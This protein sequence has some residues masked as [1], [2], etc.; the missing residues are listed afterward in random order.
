MHQTLGQL[1]GACCWFGWNMYFTGDAK[2]WWRIR[3]K[4]DA[5]SGKPQI[6]T[7]ETLKNELK[8]QFIPTNIAWV[9]S[10]SLKRFRHTRSVRDYV[11]EFSSLMLDIKNMLEEDKFFNFMSG[12]Q[13]WVRQNFRGKGFIA[14]WIT[15]WVVPSPLC[16]TKVEGGKKAKAKGKA[17]K[18]SRWKKQNKKS[19]IGVK[20]MEKTTK[21]VQQDASKERNSRPLCLQMTRENLTQRPLLESIHCNSWMSFMVKV[22]M[23][24]GATHNFMATREATGLGLKLKE[25]TIRFKAVNSKVAKNV[26]M[27]VSDW[28][29]TCSLLC[30]P[31]DDFNFILALRA[32]D[33]SKSQPKMLS[34]IQ[35]K[36]G[37]KRGHDTY[38][39]AL[40]EIKEEYPLQDISYK[41]IGAT[42]TVE[43][44]IGC[45][46][47][48]ALKGSI[49]CTS[50]TNIPTTFC[51]LMND[52]LFDYLDAFVRLR[53]HR[54]YVKPDKCEA[55]DGV[56]VQE[57]HP[58]T[59]ENRKLNSAEQK[60]S[61]REKEMTIVIHCFRKEVIVYIS[62]LSKVISDFNERIKQVV[63][64][65]AAYGKLRQQVKEGVIKRYW[66][67]GDLLVAKG[68]K[69]YI[70]RKK[71][72][73]L[74]QP[75]PIPEKPWESISMDFSTEISNERINA[76]PNEYL[77]HWMS[78]FELAIGVQPR[79]PLDVAEQKARGNILATYKL[80]QSR[81]EMFDKARDSLEKAVIWIKKYV[82]RDRRF[83]KSYYEDLDVERMQTKRAPYLVMKQF[84]QEAEKILDHKTM[85]HNRKNCRTDFL[86]Q[87][88]RTLE[89]KA[90]WEKDVT[91]WQFEEAVQPY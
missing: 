27:Q 30:V 71:A 56:L 82:D 83:L 46:P 62:D 49:W 6:T 7:W 75:L 66:L 63:Q 44:I 4:D 15:K 86:V 39:V 51:N 45:R 25:D 68:G 72:V 80:A 42:Q 22:M 26:P 89:A 60:Y 20:S 74:L 43:R 19:V 13:G 14:W 23:D 21:L 61:T 77:K 2:L 90:T 8:D 12:L 73:R 5:E 64:H 47:D 54:L 16:E 18:K 55:L 67:E 65:D 37:L 91:L 36:K 3:M 48:S 11:K 29:G 78:P 85:G 87:W 9:A 52:V 1:V 17:F 40:I 76:L 28:K 32:K 53:E 79:M 33:G 88:K 38:V 57:G 84:D 81:H 69:W 10:E 35:L 34:A 50:L 24:S 31:L 59:F 58:V 70:E 41:T